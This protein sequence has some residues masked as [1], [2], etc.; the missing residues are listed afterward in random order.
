MSSLAW[1]GVFSVDLDLDT[2]I[3]G[4]DLGLTFVK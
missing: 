4:S 1:A 3:E 2:D